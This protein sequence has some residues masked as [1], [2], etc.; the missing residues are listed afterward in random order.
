MNRIDQKR[1]RGQY[2]REIIMKKKSKQR[3]IQTNK[4]ENFP[5]L[6]RKRK[7]KQQINQ[8]FNSCSIN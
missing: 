2:L 8:L 1:T 6:F 5:I 3:F 4:Q 7:T